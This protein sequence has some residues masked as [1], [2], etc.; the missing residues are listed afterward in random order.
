MSDIIDNNNINIDIE[1]KICMICTDNIENLHICKN[2]KC[3]VY[4][5]NDCIEKIDSD[6]CPY[7]RVSNSFEIDNTINENNNTINENNNN[8]SI[9]NV[10]FFTRLMDY[11]Y[12]QIR[13]CFFV[14]LKHIIILIYIICVYYINTFICFYFTNNYCHICS[15][16]SIIFTIIIYIL[17]IMFNNKIIKKRLFTILIIDIFLINLINS[18]LLGSTCIFHLIYL[19][20]ITI[21]ITLISLNIYFEYRVI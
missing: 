3:S 13:K 17:I 8:F 9:Y 12:Q 6:K 7:C 19:L 10:Y 21:F 11:F 15:I 16:F 20:F 14:I 18:I 5:C 2:D 4:I 1:D